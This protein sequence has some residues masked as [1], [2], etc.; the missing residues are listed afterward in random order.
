MS[1]VFRVV[2]FLVVIVFAFAPDA[3]ADEREERA[4]AA[5]RQFLRLSYDGA[6]DAAA[7]LAVEN[8]KG[9]DLFDR[10]LRNVLRVRCASVVAITIR[11]LTI[12]GE[13]AAI[14]TD[15]A[16]GKSERRAPGASIPLEIA[17]YRLRLTRRSD[18]W[19]VAA[20]E[21]PDEELADQLI[22]A[23][24]D[25]RMRI[26]AAHEERL[27]R[28]LV[29]ILNRRYGMLVGTSQFGPA[30]AVAELAHSVAIASGD[31]GAEAL[32]M[33][34]KRMDASMRGDSAAISA[35]TRR[36]LVLAEESGDPDALASAWLLAGADITRTDQHSPAAADAF[37]KAIEF[38]DR[39]EDPTSMI[40]AF[41]SLSTQ[42]LLRGDHYTA[43]VLLDRVLPLLPHAPDVFSEM[44]YEIQL[45]LIYS[46]QHDRGMTLH[47]LQR[48]LNKVRKLNSPLSAVVLMHLADTLIADG[49]LDD[50]LK[51]ISEARSHMAP[52]SGIAAVIHERTG[53]VEAQKGHFAEAECLMREAAAIWARFGYK[54]G[55]AFDD[56]TPHLAR[57]GRHRD[58][59]RLSLEQIPHVRERLP[60]AAV[61]A[62]TTAAE[63]AL[64]LG[65]PERAQSLIEE[66]I[67]L[68]ETLHEKISGGN[69]QIIRSAGSTALC[70]ELAA[71]IAADRGDLNAALTL[72]ER[73][74][75]R[76]LHDILNSA[77]PGNEPLGEGD[78]ATRAK[79]EEILAALNRE[80][81]RVEANDQHDLAVRLRK[82]LDEARRDYQTFLDGLRGRTEQRVA[83]LR[84]FQ[85]SSLR[86]VVQKLPREM[87]A[88]EYVV[89][90]TELDVFVVRR[91]ATGEPIVR[92]RTMTID[93]KTLEGDIEILLKRAAVP[94]LRYRSPAERLYQ[95]LIEPLEQDLGDA[96]VLCIVPDENLWRVPF[97]ALIRRGRFL[98][99]RW[100]IV[101]AQSIAVYVAMNER[102]LVQHPADSS[103]LAIANPT[104]ADQSKRQLTSFY[105]GLVLGALPDAER[106]AGG[107]CRAYGARHCVVLTR[108]NATERRVK[109]AMKSARIMHFAT[110]G[111]FDDSNPMYSRL[112]LAGSEAASEDGALEAREIAR[113]E[114]G[115][116]L[117]VLSACDTA[118][119][120]IGNGEGV[121]G[122]A[123]SFFAAG[124]RSVV[125]TQWKVASKP[126]ADLMIAF[127][128]A[129]RAHQHDRAMKKPRALRDA[130]LRLIRAAE[131]RHPFYWSGFVLLGDAS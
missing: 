123:W 120:T 24:G 126:T 95:L 66:A 34:S 124:A 60:S 90:E 85:A 130:Q 82:R 87:A 64:A 80:L 68:R 15:V 86:E 2:A 106:E 55:P 74:R 51:T 97:A 28:N 125:A 38:G 81:A 6:F 115:A 109:D 113:L 22:A 100:P 17:R 49:R 117:V 93:R 41:Q 56:L 8:A 16:A 42:A 131:T 23:S 65:L 18:S 127:H 79:H 110:H 26:M 54:Y 40:G 4:A 84:L 32:V 12:E 25:E 116:D 89:R 57:T 45:G 30:P 33:T 92:R 101:Y 62:L 61:R 107:L 103:I 83:P 69:E 104:L 47:H 108:G 122:M 91:S 31:P 98:I 67:D 19:L 58:A 1:F 72:I 75:G 105:R 96:E 94:D 114:I 53:I 119:G 36:A 29:V 3:I 37:R 52:G 99:E 9:K 59:L 129:L 70:Y 46:Q 71:K 128:H 27:T 63:A 39:S 118:R 13:N 44:L 20:I 78:Q 76:V 10:E 112:V 5:V 35:L 11:A 7:R 77:A 102:A 21:F 14:E 73:G 48:A 121:V 50:A 111:V 88:I 43:R